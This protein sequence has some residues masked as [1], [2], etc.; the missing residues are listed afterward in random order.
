MI[1]PR[2]TSDRL[3][4]RFQDTRVV[5]PSRLTDLHQRAQIFRA[6][7]ARDTA[8][9]A[10]EPGLV[11]ARQPVAPGGASALVQ[12]Q[13]LAG[14]AECDAMYEICVA[15]C[16]DMPTKQQ[17]RLCYERCMEE[18][19]RCL[20]N[21]NRDTVPDWLL[22][23]IIVAAIVLIV[24]DGPFPIGDAAAAALLLSF[25][26]FDEETAN[27]AMARKDDPSASRAA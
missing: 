19:A 18:Y 24:A 25:G 4:Y 20:K 17:R 15:G 3:S 2:M 14:Q 22:F 6:A 10:S 8:A 9:S 7:H 16:R 5:Q 13:P 23:L 11:V 12:R 27:E 26:L 21:A 1:A